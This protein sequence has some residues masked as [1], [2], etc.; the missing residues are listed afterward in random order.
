MRII[1]FLLLA[2]ALWPDAYAAKQCGIVSQACTSGPSTVTIDG[3]E[4]TRPCWVN[5][6][7]Y[8]CI[9]EAINDT[10][11][12][13]IAKGC[14]VHSSVCQVGVTINGA[15]QCITEQRE[16]QCK[17]AEAT[18]ATVTNC[19][20]QQFCMEGNCFDTGSVPDPDFARAVSGM[21]AA[22]EAGVYIDEATFQVFKGKDNRCSKSLLNNCCKGSSSRTNGLTNLAIASGSA[23]VFDVL[24]GPGMKS[25]IVFGFDPTLFALAVAHMVVRQML[26]CDKDEVLVAVK[27]DHRL[28][29]YVGEYC[30]RKINLLFAKI[31]V[32]HT[33]TYCCFNSKI[34]R[35][36]NEAAR[37]QLPGLGWGTP[38]SP[39]CQGL[40]IA[41][42]QEMDLSV[43]DFS[44]FY[45]DIKPTEPNQTEI[46]ERAAAK[47]KSYFGD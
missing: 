4:V 26:A 5:T 16:Y 13:A 41:Q 47:V 45:A 29:H 36:I 25:A 46:T 33:E 24:G 6:T 19:A 35:V 1:I 42:F 22:R 17:V 40:S 2:A 37:T 32:E 7:D 27:R 34:S 18:S 44:E 9:E 15:F 28:C 39:S 14:S 31:C 21:E 23:Y 12:S 11:G 38:E 3:M 43:V 10:C 8:A 30:S 20:G